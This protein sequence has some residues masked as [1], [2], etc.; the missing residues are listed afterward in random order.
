METSAKA[1]DAGPIPDGYVRSRLRIAQM[2]CPTEEAMI[3]RKLA[4]RPDVHSLEFD[5]MQRVL[6]VAHAPGVLSG[7]EAAI[8]ELGMIGEALPEAV[9]GGR[10]NAAVH[11][12]DLAPVWPL[13]LGGIAA[14]GAEMAHWA[15]LSEWIAAGLALAAVAVCGTG[16][17]RKGWVALRHGALNINALMSLAVTGALLLRQWPEA[18]MVMVLFTLAERIEARSLERARRAIRGLLQLAPERA[19][20]RQPDG[21]WIDVP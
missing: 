1:V 21:R 11:G 20:V 9:G 2:D 13:A 4:G 12:D 17:Y 15:S 19:T 18:A 8:R 3:R 5:L 10:G 7:I 14:L 16:T 6:S